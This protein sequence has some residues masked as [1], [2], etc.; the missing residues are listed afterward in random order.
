MD[1]LDLDAFDR[2]A[3]MRDPFDFVVVRDFLR[4]D[5]AAAVC[6]D[7]PPI[8]HPGLLAADD[9]GGGPRFGALIEALRSAAVRG[10]FSRKFGLDLKAQ[11]QMITVRGRCQ[12]KDGRIHVDSKDKVVTALL[13]LNEPWQA[14]GGR[15]RL[16]RSADDLNDA[17]AEV[18]P[19]CGTLVAFRRSDR[20]YHGHAPYV[21][22]RRCVMFNWMIDARAARR[23]TMRHRLSAT[24]KR[25]LRGDAAS[26]AARETADA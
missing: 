21:G 23:E 1:L 16:L 12:A 9:A 14:E 24:F 8:D 19:E 26:P 11:A 4:R 25:F 6:A 15:L 18:P 13:Y 3:L 22:V 7:F 10:T 17:V 20:S 5:A 2:A